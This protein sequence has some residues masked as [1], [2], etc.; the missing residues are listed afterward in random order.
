MEAYWAA[1]PVSRTL[2]ALTFATSIL[3]HG[4]L[5]SGNRV[6]FYLPW[7]FKFPLPEVWRFITS[8]WVTG[9]GLSILFDTYF[10]WMYSSGLEKESG[11]FSQPGDFFTY[12]IFLGLVILATA[13]GILGGAI[14]TQ[15]LILAIAYTYSQDNRGKKVSFFIITFN[16]MWLPWAMLLMT[17]V[18]AG[19]DA[20]LNQAMGLIAAHLYD[21]LT[22]LYPTFGGGRNVIHT[23]AIVKRWFGADKPGIQVRGYGTSY[24]PASQAPG[25][26]TSNGFGFSS[27]WGTRGQGRRLGG[28]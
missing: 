28:D 18:L 1:P 8:F 26:G 4:G 6:V 14:F 7:I 25:R 13:G 21:F 27:A 20:A 2:T 10:L 3:V 23:P 22:R 5:L 15:A 24:R 17:F 12:I 16:V 9:G 11:R 19:P